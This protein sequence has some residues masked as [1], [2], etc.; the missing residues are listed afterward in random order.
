M[1]SR[2]VV[3]TLPTSLLRCSVAKHPA[4]STR[5]MVIVRY[6]TRAAERYQVRARIY[7]AVVDLL[8]AKKIP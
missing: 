6:I 5:V 8:R 7:R 2:G 1:E 3:F 4:G